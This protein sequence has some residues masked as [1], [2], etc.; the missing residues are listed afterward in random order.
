MPMSPLRLAFL[1]GALATRSVSIGLSHGMFEVYEQT[2]D[3][4]PGSIG[5]DGGSA[6]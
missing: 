3:E 4:M 5:F 1:A 2:E 6:A